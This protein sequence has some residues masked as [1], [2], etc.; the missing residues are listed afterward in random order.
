MFLASTLVTQ[1]NIQRKVE[2]IITVII[3]DFFLNFFREHAKKLMLEND[4]LQ[5]TML[6]SEQEAIEIF[7]L[8]QKKDESK[9]LSVSL[10]LSPQFL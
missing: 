2:S 9:N 7:T 1:L 10:G 6:R 8:L 4:G 5:S 3:N